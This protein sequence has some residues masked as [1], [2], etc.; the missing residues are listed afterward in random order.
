MRFILEGYDGIASL[1]TV[2]PHSGIIC[3]NIPPGCEDEV[4]TVLQEMKTDV[5]IAQIDA[6][7]SVV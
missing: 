3:L 2:D 7:S 5:L 4:E 1:T 6:G